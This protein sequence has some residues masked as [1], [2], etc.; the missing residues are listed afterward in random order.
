MSDDSPLHEEADVNRNISCGDVPVD[1]DKPL[2]RSSCSG[3]GPVM[4]SKLLMFPLSASNEPQKEYLKVLQGELNDYHEMVRQLEAVKSTMNEELEGYESELVRLDNA[5]M[6]EDFD[7]ALNQARRAIADLERVIDVTNDISDEEEEVASIAEVEKT[8]KVSK[9][10]PKDDDSDVANSHIIPA[11]VDVV[12]KQKKQDK[13]K[14]SAHAKVDE[15]M[16]ILDEEVKDIEFK[17]KD[18]NE[19]IER[20]EEIKSKLKPIDV[21]GY[22]QADNKQMRLRVAVKATMEII[23]NKKQ[24]LEVIG[25]KMKLLGILSP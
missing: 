2:N 1:N 21:E 18:Y 6:V 14:S 25:K 20:L 4:F 11:G 16:E 19:R 8:N 12:A 24:E 22:K 10:A 13:K 3:I 17:L 5:E 9:H 23:E 7:R 15:E